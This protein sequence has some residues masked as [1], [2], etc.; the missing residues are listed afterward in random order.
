M[1]FEGLYHQYETVD[2]V[3]DPSIRNFV[4]IPI[5]IVVIAKTFLT[6]NLMEIM[7]K[8]P[9]KSK[10]DKLM[11]NNVLSRS[12][13]LRTNCNWL[14]ED[15]FERRRAQF[16]TQQLKDI[17]I[18]EAPA[19]QSV[20]D[21]SNMLGMM[22][23]NTV[24]MFSHIGFMFWVNTF[25]TGFLIIRLPFPVS[26]AYRSIVQR[27]VNMSS[28]ECSYV[29]S[30]SWYFL[31]LFGFRGLTTAISGGAVAD[32][33]KMMKEQMNN[34]MAAA[35]GPSMGKYDPNPKFKYEREELGIVDQRWNLAH[36]EQ[37]LLDVWS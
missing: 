4:L 32:D 18:E 2:L 35:A 23:G 6:T 20:Q 1:G 24:S 11:H 25:F 17:N 16:L 30:L 29:S 37:R 7:K 22:Q 15:S 5:L 13:R 27:G 28:L 36:V 12:G 34:P 31:S 14:P 9:P 8:V 3:L 26:E 33:M 10:K 21:M 19:E